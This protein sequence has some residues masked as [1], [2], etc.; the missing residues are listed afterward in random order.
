MA[1]VISKLMNDSEYT[2]VL[3]GFQV[4]PALLRLRGWFPCTAPYVPV[5]LLAADGEQEQWDRWHRAVRSGGDILDSVQQGTVL[6]VHGL[7]HAH[8]RVMHDLQRL[9]QQLHHRRVDGCCVITST[10]QKEEVARAL[11][12]RCPPSYP[13]P[14]RHLLLP[15]SALK[16]AG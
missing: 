9:L 13:L 8:L 14:L 10:L 5:E 3:L 7:E 6:W 12:A 11:T 4:T 16:T 1:S 2:Y 15:H